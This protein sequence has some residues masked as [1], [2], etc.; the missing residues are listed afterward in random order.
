MVLGEDVAFDMVERE[1]ADHRAVDPGQGHGQR[2]AQRGELGRIV[3]IAGLHRRVAVEDRL[4]VLG[5]P[6]RQTLADRNLQRREQ[7]E[8]VAA[9]ELG[10]QAVVA[11]HVDGH[12]VV[13]NHALQADCQ[14]GERL[15]QAER[16]AQALGQFEQ[17]MSFLPRGRDLGEEFRRVNCRNRGLLRRRPRRHPGI[18][19]AAQCR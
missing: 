18:R 15:V 7:P 2:G 14:D 8:V 5:H 3:Q 4:A 9:D 17:R 19:P 12:R 13:G 16:V 1:H 11:A 10:Q 6:A